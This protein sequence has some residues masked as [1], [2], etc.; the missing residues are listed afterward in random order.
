MYSLFIMHALH[1]VES[2]QYS[3]E[4]I[5]FDVLASFDFFNHEFESFLPLCL[6]NVANNFMC[7]VSIVEF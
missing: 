6:A 7:R 3:Q 2:K 1:P 4:K 5:S